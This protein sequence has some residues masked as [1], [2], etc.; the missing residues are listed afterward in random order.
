MPKKPPTAIWQV[1]EAEKLNQTSSRLA[2]LALNTAT[3]DADFYRAAVFEAVNIDRRRRAR[4]ARA[5]A[6]G[7]RVEG[8]PVDPNENPNKRSGGIEVLNKDNIDPQTA[9]RLGQTQL[10]HYN[11]MNPLNCNIL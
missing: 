1:K 11:L 9:K 5:R 6:A 2:S 3:S 8:D 7:Q 4:E 10:D